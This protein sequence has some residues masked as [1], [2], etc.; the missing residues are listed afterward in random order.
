[1]ARFTQE[2][3][4]NAKEV[5]ILD[6]LNFNG[7]NVKKVGTNEYTLLEHDSIRINPI[8]NTFF[9]NSQNVGGGVIQFLQVYENKSLVEA[10]HILNGKSISNSKMQNKQPEKNIEIKGD[11]VLPKKNIDNKRVQAYL[12]KSRKIDFEIVNSLI[13]SGNIYEDKDKHNIIFVGKDKDN[14]I[15]Y[16]SKRSTLTNNKFK[17]DCKNSDKD[18]GFR[19]KGTNNDKVYIFESAID[20]MT[21]ATISKN[22]G[23]DWKEDNRIS[24]GSLSFKTLD[25]FLLD[26]TNVK[27]LVLFLDS[28]K[29][30]IE[31]ANKLYKNYGND[32]KVSIVAVKNKDLNQTWQDYLIDKEVNKNIRFTNYIKY[33]D[34]PF[35]EP[36]ILEN[37]EDLEEYLKSVFIEDLHKDLIKNIFETENKKAVFLIKD[38]N[39][40]NIGGYEWDIYNKDYNLKL[41]ENSIEKPLFF[42]SAKNEDS[43]FVYDNIVCTLAMNNVINTC[44]IDNIEN[45]ENIDVI[46]KENK[47]LNNIFLFTDENTNLYMEYKNE[48]SKVY[49]S[50][51]DKEKKYNVKIGIED[52]SRDNYKNFIKKEYIKDRFTPKEKGDNNELYKTLLYKT[53]IPKQKLLML[54]KNNIIYQDI[55]RNMVFLIKDENGENIGGYELDI[56]SKKPELKKLENTY[57]N[58]EK[59]EKILN[60]AT[61]IFKDINGIS[62]DLEMEKTLEME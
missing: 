57:I 60:F 47:N 37:K 8:R 49:K 16:A 56:Y 11:I 41:L 1:M 21:H 46:V 33:L 44:Y 25:N 45:L 17:G 38:E 19:I 13:K 58:E 10:I 43:V 40:E 26:N 14:N 36:K 52:W 15:K 48:N 28:D 20:L 35:L 5:N 7:Y 24:L 6:Y 3:Y 30:G 4:E 42:K 55:D 62:N 29:K 27:E 22:L 2:E 53:N 50:I 9:W 12:T 51:K 34:K 54:F 18:F 39:E 23:K 31:N 59:E 32:Y 61:Y